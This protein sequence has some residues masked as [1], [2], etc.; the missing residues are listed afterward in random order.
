[1]TVIFTVE[2]HGAVDVCEIDQRDID[3]RSIVDAVAFRTYPAITN[4]EL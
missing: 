1:M 2:C 3:P 4:G